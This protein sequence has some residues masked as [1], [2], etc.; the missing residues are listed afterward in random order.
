MEPLEPP[1]DPPLLSY[2]ILYTYVMYTAQQV[3]YVVRLLV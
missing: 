1:L 3:H 2:T